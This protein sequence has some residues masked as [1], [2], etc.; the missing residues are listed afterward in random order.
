MDMPSARIRFNDDYERFLHI[1]LKISQLQEEIATLKGE[2]YEIAKRNNFKIEK[3]NK[4]T[5]WVSK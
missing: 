2:R 1:E 4:P 5:K 3:P